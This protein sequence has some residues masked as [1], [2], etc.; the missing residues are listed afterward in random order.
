MRLLRS[1]VHVAVV[2]AIVG[3]GHGRDNGCQGFIVIYL[4]QGK[5]IIRHVDDFVE[6][7]IAKIVRFLQGK[8]GSRM[9]TSQSS[10]RRHCLL[11]FMLLML[12]L[13][14][15]FEHGHAKQRIG[16]GRHEA[17][18]LVLGIK[19]VAVAVAVVLIVHHHVLGVK[20]VV[21]VIVGRLKDLIHGN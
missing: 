7:Q 15:P 19:T 8:K 10:R 14:F 5:G 3:H 2:V 1:K 9:I 18:E 11:M 20:V 6:G 16:R 4:F 17:G 12:M 21:V 13:G